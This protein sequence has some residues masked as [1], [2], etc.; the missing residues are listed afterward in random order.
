MSAV[1][2]DHGMVGDGVGREQPQ[3]VQV[4]HRGIAVVL[5]AVGHLPGGLGQVDDP[6]GHGAYRP[7]ALHFCSRSG[8]QVYTAWG[9]TAT[10][11]R[12]WPA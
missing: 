3:A 4:R 2:Q 1:G 5:Q 9:S 6:A 8:E 7:V 12:G 10:L 11:T